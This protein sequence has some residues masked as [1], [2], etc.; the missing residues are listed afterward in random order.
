MTNVYLIGLAGLMKSLYVFS[1]VKVS[2]GV[3]LLLWQQLFYPSGLL[4]F[5]RTCRTVPYL[6]LELRLRLNMRYWVVR[7]SKLMVR[8]GDC[9]ALLTSTARH[10]YLPY[11]D[12]RQIFDFLKTLSLTDVSP[13]V[14]A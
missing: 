8:S 2:L 13:P 14:L 6:L 7:L 12:G 3:S 11:R 4:R 10:D 9:H 1:L 5:C